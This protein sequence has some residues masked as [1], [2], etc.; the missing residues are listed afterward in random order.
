MSRRVD[1]A[2]N[3]VLPRKKPQMDV[4]EAKK[5]LA[6]LDEKHGE[7][8]GARSERQRYMAVILAGDKKPK[9]KTRRG[10]RGR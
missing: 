5:R 3:E 8:V 6:A 2:T 7:G 9:K 10:K 4:D 1:W